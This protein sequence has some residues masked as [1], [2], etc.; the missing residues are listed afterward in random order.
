MRLIRYASGAREARHTHEEGSITLIL[1]GIVEEF[2]DEKHERGRP[3]SVVVKPPGVPHGNE[4]GAE[5]VLTFQITLSPSRWN[6]LVTAGQDPGPWRWIDDTDAA[7]A[8]LRL[9]RVA[10]LQSGPHASTDDLLHETLA[11]LPTTTLPHHKAAPA[12]LRHV[13]E[14][15]EVEP[16]TVA[17]LA[18]EVGVHPVHL[19]REFRKSFGQTPSQ[20]RRSARLRRTAVSLSD[21]RRTLA[22]T[23][24]LA[25]YADQA[26]MNREIRSTTGL[27]PR[28]LRNLI[29]SL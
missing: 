4:Y 11:A 16:K 20:Y 19:A 17:S 18:A 25:G 2:V 7:G 29:S 23:S 26:H 10:S 15:L 3:L 22:E 9:L 28:G 5:G 24:Q 21:T 12:W 6:A 13:R 8:M 1:R 27:T 14:A